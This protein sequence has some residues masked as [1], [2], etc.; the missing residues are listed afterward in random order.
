MTTINNINKIVI[1]FSKE[2]KKP[3]FLIILLIIF[4][5]CLYITFYLYKVINQMY[6]EV[7]LELFSIGST[8]EYHKISKKEREETK[9]YKIAKR[10]S[11]FIEQLT[12]N[13]LNK[14]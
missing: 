13:I 2:I 11:N 4:V 5:I 12:T 14:F 8:T 9:N 1:L 6:E 10:V 7:E 3:Y